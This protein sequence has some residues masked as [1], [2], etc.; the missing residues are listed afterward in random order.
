MAVPYKLL[1]TGGKLPHNKDLRAVL[2]VYETVGIKLLGDR[3]VKATSLTMG[4][5]VGALEAIRYELVEQLMLG[6]RVHLPGLGYFSLS[7]K[8][9]LYE[10]PNT[11]KFRLRNPYVRTVNFRPE[12]ELLRALSGTRFENVTHR[13]EP[14]RTPTPQDVD[15]ALARLFAEADYIFVGDLQAELHLSRPVAYRL[16]RRLEAEG[17]LENVGSRYRKMFVRGGRETSQVT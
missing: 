11:H 7:V 1:K 4:D 8:G 16:A 9:E 17:K 10:D 15:A 14:H 12:K 2:D 3:I 5:L 13:Y 6:N